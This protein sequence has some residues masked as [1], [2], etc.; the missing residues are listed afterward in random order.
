[1]KKSVENESLIIVHFQHSFLMIIYIDR[2]LF[3]NGNILIVPSILI[4]FSSVV[5]VYTSTTDY[6]V[7]MPITS[8]TEKRRIPIIMIGAI[9]LIMIV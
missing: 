3:F 5:F 2:T 4:N 7:M 6:T 8:I 1:M 9:Y